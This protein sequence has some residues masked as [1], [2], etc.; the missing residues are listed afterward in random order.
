MAVVIALYLLGM[1][2]AVNRIRRHGAIDSDNLA[3]KL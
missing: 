1:W 2:L 3:K